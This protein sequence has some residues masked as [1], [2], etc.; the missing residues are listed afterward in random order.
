ER[1]AVAGVRVRPVI[2]ALDADHPSAG[3][4]IVAADLD[5]SD[6]AAGVVAAEIDPWRHP[7]PKDVGQGVILAQPQA[8]A[9]A[10]DIAAGPAVEIN[11]RCLHRRWWRGRWRAQIRGQCGLSDDA[12]S[13]SQEC[14]AT[15]ANPLLYDRTGLYA[16]AARVAASEPGRW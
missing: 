2:V 14:N 10:A 7:H 8:A 16:P 6:S 12:E 9:V 13:C 1:I 15:H 4:L 11:H 5:A 3:K